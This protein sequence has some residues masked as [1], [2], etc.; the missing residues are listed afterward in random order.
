MKLHWI[1]FVKTLSYRILGVLGT[2]AVVFLITGN[3]RI[4]ATVGAVDVVIKGLFYYFHELLWEKI[5]VKIK[6]KRDV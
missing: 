2:M 4:S 6:E 5:T 1:A 3:F